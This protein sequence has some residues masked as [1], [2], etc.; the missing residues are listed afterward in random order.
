[1]NLTQLALE[2]KVFTQ[3]VVFLLVVGGI[4]SFMGLGRLEDPDFT[5]KIGVIITQYPGASAEEVELEVTDRIEAALQEM[6]QLDTTYSISRAGLSIIKVDMKQKYW[7]DTLPQVWD[8]MRKKIRDVMPHM[9][10]GVSHPEIV[11]DF[12][13]VFGFVLAVT[14]DG[15]SYGE[16]EEYVKTIKKEMSLVPGVSRVDL[17]GVQPKVVYLDISD[18]QLAALRITKEDVLAT[19]TL[20]NM[21]VNSGHVEVPGKRLRIETTGEFSTPEDIGNLVIRRSFGDIVDSVANELERGGKTRAD[22]GALGTL[23]SGSASNRSNELIR[24]RDVATVRLDYLDPPIMQMR[25]QGEPALAVQLANVT[26]GNLL[27][28]GAALDKRLEEVLENLPAGINVEKFVWQSDLVKESIDGF[29]INLAEAVLIVLVVLTLAMGWRMGLVIG[30]A[31]IVTILGTFI[32]MKLLG[33]DLQRVSLGALVVALGMMVDNAIVVADNYSVRL[34]KGMKPVDA[35]IDSAKGPSIALLGATIVAI[36]AFYPVYSAQADAG[37]YGQTLFIVVGISLLWSWLISMTVTPLNCMA[38]LKPPSDT[39]QTSDPYDTGFFHRYK[40]IL[41]SA[42]RH[43]YRTIG[44]MTVLLIAAGYGF[45]RYVPQQFFPDSTRAQFMVD[46]W[47]PMGTPIEAVSEDLRAIETRL[48]EDP[49][50]KSVGTFVGAGGPRFYLPV[51]PEFPYPE[52]GQ[53]IVNTPSFAEVDPL[54]DELRA[55]LQAEYPQAMIRVR[56]YTVG[57]GDTWPFELRIAGPA[58]ADLGELRRLGEEGMSILHESPLAKNV[59]IDMRQRVQKVVVDYSQTRGRWSTTTRGDVARA[60]SRAYDGAP[61]GI[62]RDGDTLIPI[63]TRNEEESRQTVAGNLESVQVQ[64][65][66]NV[67]T[68]PLGQLADDIRMEWEDPIITRFNRRRQVA[69]Q[70]SPVDVT[71]PT[72]RSSVIEEFEAMELPP[73]FD[74]FWDGE[75]DSTLRAQL[76]LLPG[77]VPGSVIMVLIIVALFNAVRPLLV[78]LL[79]VPFALIGITAILG[80]TQIPFGFMAMLGAMSLV[81]LMIKNSIVL[82][83]EID[84]N[85]ATGLSR[86]DSILSAGISRLRPV[87]LGAATTILGVI[88]LIQDAFWISMALTIMFGLL[89]GTILTMVM[90]PVFYS[91][92]YKVRSPAA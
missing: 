45:V 15:Y 78:M 43:R 50:V 46:Y 52:F 48:I 16:L 70:A 28:T 29:V 19:L 72:L 71:L 85:M 8:E 22:T 36:M 57:P 92:L 32:V 37:E 83:D 60:T 79:T 6:P 73:G 24:I 62:F 64:A 2:K 31:L 69:V 90:V 20:Q 26:G 84:V 23:Q 33:I 7:A 34:A 56:K 66:L 4:F 44:L 41:E 38:L 63:M 47:A 18:T 21:V 75:Y 58:E 3:F 77:M 14:G 10:P 39:E 67:R 53:L 86:Y 55:T 74:L 30:W 80:P 87:I 35:A 25:F 81:G 40:A 13:F 59:R 76:S 17:W 54:V 9:P 1:M 65:P 27:D 82:L 89:F 12:S 49:R 68:T 88:P 51:D 5:V 11:D 42:I 61:V 91:T